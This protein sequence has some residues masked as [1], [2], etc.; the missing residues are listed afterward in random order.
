MSTVQQHVLKKNL[1]S[2]QKAKVKKPQFFVPAAEVLHQAGIEE[3]VLSP[4]EGDNELQQAIKTLVLT[5]ATEVKKED[6]FVHSNYIDIIEKTN[7]FLEMAQTNTQNTAVEN[8]IKNLTVRVGYSH[9]EPIAFKAV[10]TVMVVSGAAL[11]AASVAF[12]I[13][14]A[15]V[16]VGLIVGGVCIFALGQC[17][18][19][20][21]SDKVAT[22]A[23][24]AL[25]SL[26][27]LV[28]N[29][30]TTEAP[31]DEDSAQFKV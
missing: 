31:Q 24:E 8:E 29:C 17:L 30:I 6:R 18:F 25:H 28:S 14:T 15:A 27:D 9:K 3:G 16:A 4:Q 12:G 10:G 20:K 21:D 11:L 7:Q 23:T 13:L 2:F 5:L 22:Q 26:P 19:A 1:A